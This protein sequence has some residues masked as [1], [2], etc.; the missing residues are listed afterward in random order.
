MLLPG[1]AAA[2]LATAFLR[3]GLYQRLGPTMKRVVCS[4]MCS[5]RCVD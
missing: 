1:W 4:G 3:G 5:L 2:V